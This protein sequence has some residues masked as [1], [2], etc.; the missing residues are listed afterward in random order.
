MLNYTQNCLVENTEYVDSGLTFFLNDTYR[1]ENNAN[2]VVLIKN[3]N[4]QLGQKLAF[5]FFLS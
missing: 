1:L 5:F 4:N 3:N 2:I